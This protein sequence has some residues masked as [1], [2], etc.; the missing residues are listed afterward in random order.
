MYS[1]GWLISISYVACPSVIHYKRGHGS[2]VGEFFSLYS[3]CAGFQC[4]GVSLGQGYNHTEALNQGYMYIDTE[5]D[6]LIH[7]PLSPI[8]YNSLFSKVMIE[9]KYC[10]CTP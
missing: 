3:S 8:P 7:M 6:S 10:Y 5:M 1:S 9:R 2:L 4:F